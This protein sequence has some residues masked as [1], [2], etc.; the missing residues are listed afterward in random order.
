MSEKKEAN[1]GTVPTA[2]GSL[3]FMLDKYGNQGVLSTILR[4]VFVA[5]AFGNE[6][7]GVFH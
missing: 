1:R 3:I 5:E 6:T 2:S 7:H 4:A